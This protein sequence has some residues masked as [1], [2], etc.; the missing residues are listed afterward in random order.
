MSVFCGVDECIDIE[1]KII[2]SAVASCSN[3][4]ANVVQA[5]NKIDSR[6]VVCLWR[7]FQ[8]G[9]SALKLKKC[10]E[11]LYMCDGAAWV[12]GRVPQASVDF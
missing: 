4:S 2:F 5:T 12:N 7:V 1:L 11:P 3:S 8:V 10:L 9:D 6:K